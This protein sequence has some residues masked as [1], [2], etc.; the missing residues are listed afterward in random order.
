MENKM[1]SNID[2]HDID[3]L[4]RLY[5]KKHE[6][7][8]E[9][10]EEY[11]GFAESMAQTER[12]YRKEKSKA[13]LKRKVDGIQATLIPAVVNGDVSDVRMKFKISESLFHGCRENIKRLHSAIDMFRSLL[14]TAKSE[15]NIR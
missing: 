3:K 5:I 9:A 14:S 15:I 1:K 4:K 11:K 10:L 7:L 6:Q 13:T 2:F 8:A 12:D